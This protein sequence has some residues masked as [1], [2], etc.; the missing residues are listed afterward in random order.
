MCARALLDNAELRFGREI[1][2]CAVSA[3]VTCPSFA[4]LRCGRECG[5][6]LLS[7]ERWTLIRALQG[8]SYTLVEGGRFQRARL[9]FLT[10]IDANLAR[11]VCSAIATSVRSLF[12][13]LNIGLWCGREDMTAALLQS[14]ARRQFHVTFGP[15]RKPVS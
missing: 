1:Q 14:A 12:L 15:F 3:I 8:G 7:F 6:E 10:G 2:M 4:L 9:S 11:D 13:E 5:R